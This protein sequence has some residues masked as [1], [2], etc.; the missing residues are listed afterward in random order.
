MSAVID[1]ARAYRPINGED[2]IEAILME[3][4]KA[5]VNSGMFPLHR[6]WHEFEFQGGVRVKGWATK[7]EEVK[8]E[9]KQGDL[10]MRVSDSGDEAYGFQSVEGRV[11]VVLRDEPP[12][13][14]R[15]RIEE[16][17]AAAK[18]ASDLA[19]IA[20]EVE[21]T[22]TFEGGTLEPL[23][24]ETARAMVADGPARAE[25]DRHVAEAFACAKCGRESRTKAGKV[26][27]ER[28]C[29]VEAKDVI[30]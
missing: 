26:A 6:V 4:R 20:G 11:D 12:S 30:S 1:A 21:P 25:T 28:F 23:S 19:I 7:T 2:A 24:S 27:H 18:F 5:L 17:K 14:T 3:F 8:F 9:V 29:K 15:E 13:V 16:A 10:E 22:A